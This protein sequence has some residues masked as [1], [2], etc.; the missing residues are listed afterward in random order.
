MNTYLSIQFKF[1]AAAHAS[2]V[3]VIREAQEQQ[4][5]HK[6]P[7]GNCS[8]FTDN[9]QFQERLHHGLIGRELDVVLAKYQLGRPQ[10]QL[11]LNRNVENYSGIGNPHLDTINEQRLAPIRFNVL[12]DGDPAHKIYWW[13][14][15]EGDPRIEKINYE[16]HGL[17]RWR[18]QVVG[19]THEQRIA[20][21]GVPDNVAERIT[22]PQEKAAFLRTDIVHAVELVANSGPRSVLSL[23]F[24]SGAWPPRIASAP[25]NGLFT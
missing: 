11:V 25:H 16:V 21:I 6:R 7:N 4:E 5:L 3:N 22:I 2:L 18:K 12:V 9:K 15:T 10:Y 20:A 24:D 19:A 17:R 1:T 8:W 23:R 14:I 13:N